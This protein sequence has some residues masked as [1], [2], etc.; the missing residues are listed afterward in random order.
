M[1]RHQIGSKFVVVA[2]SVMLSATPCNVHLGKD[3]I[4]EAAVTSR[5]QQL[6]FLVTKKETP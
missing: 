5:E 2:N 1:D 3:A 4:K 6:P